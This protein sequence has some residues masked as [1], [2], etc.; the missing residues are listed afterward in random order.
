MEEGWQ[1][2]EVNT[3]RESWERI[4]GGYLSV[5][6]LAREQLTKIGVR[7]RGGNIVLLDYFIMIFFTDN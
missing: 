4:P 2:Q 6:L 1:K 3:K 5:T 7:R